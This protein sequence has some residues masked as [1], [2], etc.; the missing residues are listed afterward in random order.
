MTMRY[1]AGSGD[2]IIPDDPTIQARL[3]GKRSRERRWVYVGCAA[4]IAFF[5]VLSLHEGGNPLYALLLAVT[6]MQFVRPTLFVWSLLLI[7]FGGYA[8]AVLFVSRS[9]D[10]LGWASL[11]VLPAAMLLWARPRAPGDVAAQR[12]R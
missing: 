12:T 1:D 4:V 10:A 2:P 11:G 5:E 6:I 7:V 8:C 3:F 9:G